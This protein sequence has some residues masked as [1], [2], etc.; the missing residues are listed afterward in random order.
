M[1]TE[2]AVS[3][4]GRPAI[5]N[6]S[7]G[8]YHFV[9][10]FVAGGIAG[11][12]AK[13]TIA[14]LDRVKILLQAHSPH[15]KDLGVVAT[16]RAVPKKE[17]YLG[18]YKGNGAMMVRIFPYGAIQFMAFDK[19]KK[20]LSK[21]LGISGH[22]HRLMAGSMAG[23]TAVI[24]TY[25]LD[26]IRARLAY[27][28]KGHHRYTGIGNA[29]QTIYL[30]EG[31]IPGFYKGLIPTLIGMAPYAGFSFFTFGTLK[32]LG[33]VHFPELLGR[34]SSDNP[35]VMVLK[36]HVNLLCG[37]VAGA[38]AQTI[39]YPLDVARRRMQLGVVLPDS[40]KCLTLTKTLKYVYSQYG[41]KKGLYRGL[42]LN[43]IRC[44][45]SQAVAFTTYEFMKQTLHL[46]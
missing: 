45:P 29:F 14:P 30:K 28:V 4:P 2:A 40:D 9:R 43:Y 34:P 23:M 35:E 12:C 22:I 27:Q 11:C 44:V 8:D 31:G 6:H 32:S 19:Y 36:T 38:I 24:C 17:G 3:T 15:Y 25:P 41:M 20:I 10:S 18:L 46:N 1:A 16:L 7:Q 42:S 37:G 21:Q 13:S 39:S 33:L 5:P 26:V